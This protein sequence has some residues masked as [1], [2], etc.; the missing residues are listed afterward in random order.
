MDKAR[1]LVGD[2]KEHARGLDGYGYNIYD[3]LS[4]SKPLLY[5]TVMWYLSSEIV[6]R[7]NL[8][9]KINTPVLPQ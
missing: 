2:V 6:V 7:C 9:T 3:P 4:V 1:E 8:F 5:I